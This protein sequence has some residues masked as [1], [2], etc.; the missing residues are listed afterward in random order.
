MSTELNI[1]SQ[2]AALAAPPS[3]L[4]IDFNSSLFQLKPATLSVNQPNT[5]VDGAIKGKL[6]LSDT[7]DQFDELFCTL[8]M[9]P[10]EKRAYYLKTGSDLN[11]QRENLMCLCSNVQRN[12][13]RIETTGP[14]TKSKVAQAVRCNGCQKSSW[15]KWRQSKLKEDLP[16]CDLYYY[17]LLIDT[18]YKMPMQMFI[19]SKAKQPF[20]QGMEK[21]SRRFLMMKSQGLN[22]NIFDIGFTLKTK[23]IK[24]GSTV[25]Y[26][27]ELTDFRSISPEERVE[28]GAIY[29][30]F[31]SRQKFTDNTEEPEAADQ[32][33]EAT[34]TI[35]A[36]VTGDVGQVLEGEIVI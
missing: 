25:S 4:G 15:E 3:G 11:R 27:P 18:K 34:E 29:Q 5:Q 33:A 13:Q 1:R 17:A 12:A 20:E 28:F 6:R 19:R 7:G 32:I 8:L 35:D 21:L 9:M 23:Q 2:S 30:Q 26:V 31:V 14:D 24:N 36:Q 16:P 22:P 10:T